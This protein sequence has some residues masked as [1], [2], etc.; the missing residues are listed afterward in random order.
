MQPQ[1]STAANTTPPVLRAHLLREDTTPPAS[2]APLLREDTTPPASRAPLL[3][4]EGKRRC[5][6]SIALPFREWFPLLCKEGWRASS[7]WLIA[8]ALTPPRPLRGHPSSER[9]GRGGV[10]CQSPSRFACAAVV[11]APPGAAPRVR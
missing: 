6:M 9:R 2:R 5:L 4:E 10:S 3:S 7:G 1:R 11:A 8:P